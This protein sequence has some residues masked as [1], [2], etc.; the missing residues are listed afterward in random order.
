MSYYEDKIY[1]D[2]YLDGYY[3]GM[4]L[5]H[6]DEMASNEMT[7]EEMRARRR[8]EIKARRRKRRRNFAL[9]TAGAVAGGALALTNPNIRGAVTGHL[10]TEGRLPKNIGVGI[11]RA[12]KGLYNF[13]PNRA[14]W[15]IREGAGAAGNAM[16][17][18]TPT[19]NKFRSDVASDI[20]VLYGE[21]LEKLKKKVKGLRKRK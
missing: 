1:H 7:K 2:G 17:R 10:R 16:A 11:G 15:K 14:T 12:G 20:D 5:Y 18:F 13:K 9:G 19:Y 4:E 3:A 6:A 8:D 21:H